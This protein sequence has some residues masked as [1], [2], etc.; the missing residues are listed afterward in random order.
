MVSMAL[1]SFSV[2]L[3]LN[4]C[5]H[6]FKSFFFDESCSFLVSLTP[7]ICRHFKYTSWR[8]HAD[9]FHSSHESGLS[10]LTQFLANGFGSPLINFSRTVGSST[11]YP[12]M[13]TYHSNLAMYSPICPPSMRSFVSSWQAL[14]CIMVSTNVFPK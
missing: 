11:P 6:L 10:I 14:A 7:K 3:L 2:C 1:G 13:A 9:S 12:A 5:R 8:L 4:P